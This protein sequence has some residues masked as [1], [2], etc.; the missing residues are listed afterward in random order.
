[1]RRSDLVRLLAIT[2][3]SLLAAAALHAQADPVTAQTNDADYQDAL[4]H[5]LLEYQLG[6]WTEAKIFFAQ[7]H[8]LRPTARTLRGLALSCYESRNYVETGSFIEQ[9]LASTVQPLTPDMR[10]G[11]EKLLTLTRSFISHVYVVLE[12]ASSELRVDQLLAQRGPD[13]S[14]A[15]D[16][17]EHELSANAPG[18]ESATRSVSAAGGHDVHI[19]F[20][21]QASSP[22]PPPQ[23]LAATTTRTVPLP[24]PDDGSQ[25][26]VG[27]FILAGASGALLIGGAVMLGLAAADKATVEHPAGGTKW[28]EVQSAYE[29]GSS[30]FPVGFVLLGVGAA[31]VA[32]ALTWQLWPR[33]ERNAAGLTLRASPCSVSI[34]GRL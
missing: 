24:E 14:V 19:R 9:A 21:L 33:S 13:G 23:L 12:P 3:L 31:G 28:A 1:M 25:R 27:P 8:A 16:P 11:L 30:L 6:H 26:G 4:D 22:P 18:Y 17:G 15:V 29:R 34:A 2:C 20:V 32:S 7:A 5:A 10:A